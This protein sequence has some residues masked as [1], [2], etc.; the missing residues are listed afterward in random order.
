MFMMCNSYIFIYWMFGEK[1]ILKMI[2]KKY[3]KIRLRFVY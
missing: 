2:L 3:A 1:M